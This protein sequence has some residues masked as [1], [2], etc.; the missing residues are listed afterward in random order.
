MEFRASSFDFVFHWLI[1]TFANSL[2]YLPMLK[3][4]HSQ[5][6]L[7][8]AYIQM[9]ISVLLWG[10]TGVLGRGIQ[11][12]EAL[13]VWYRII[14]ASSSLF[15]FNYFTGKRFALP[16]KKILQ[17]AG[18]G[19]VL[20]THWL[21]FYGAIKY[22][23]VSITLSLFSS[24]TLFT[25]L[26]EPLIT[27]KK[28]NRME[29][30]YSLLAMTGIA[31]VF[32]SDTN[33]YT[34]GII[35]AVLSAFVGAF[36]NILNKQVIH[37]VPSEIASFYEIIAGLVVL[38]LI[39]PLYIHHFHPAKLLPDV[40]DWVL[41]FILAIVCTHVALMLSLNSLKHLSA[42]T[43][44]LAV[45]LEPVYGI[46]LA[47]VI[48]GENLSLNGGFYTGTFLILLSVGLHSYFSVRSAPSNHP[49]IPS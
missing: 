38:T 23:N 19:V 17:L 9:H 1:R 28:F 7:T 13:L 27:K 26:I 36:F 49:S 2:T 47:F 6:T 21:L 30:L 15:L 32:Y 11:L 46:A 41:L 16:G 40:H 10:A 14:I 34:T 42:F 24:T 33:S 35:L 25:A 31:I 44:N 37:D 48:F 39:L 8:K 12:N 4:Y 18:I 3:A 22:S 5:S 45:N 20:M 43:L 29:M